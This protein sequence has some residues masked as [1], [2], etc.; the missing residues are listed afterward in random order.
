[1]FD[2]RGHGIELFVMSTPL[3]DVCLFT[4]CC[5]VVV[6]LSCFV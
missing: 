5:M 3:F 4:F 1:M 2:P 6:S